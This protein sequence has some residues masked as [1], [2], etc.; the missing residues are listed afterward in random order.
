M[1]GQAILKEVG[2]FVRFAKLFFFFIY[3]NARKHARRKCTLRGHGSSHCLLR[4]FVFL[5]VAGFHRILYLFTMYP[6]QQEKKEN[7]KKSVI[8]L[9]IVFFSPKKKW[10]KKYGRKQWAQSVAYGYSVRVTVVVFFFSRLSFVLPSFDPDFRFSN[11]LLVDRTERC[12]IGV[13]AR[14]AFHL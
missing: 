3:K 5:Y 10:V 11:S 14:F 2:H 13:A 9:R 7:K 6:L 8:V 4:T 12:S 1:H